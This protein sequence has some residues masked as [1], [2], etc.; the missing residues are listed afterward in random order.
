[1][2]FPRLLLLQPS[3][4]MEGTD[5][6]K[7]QFTNSIAAKVQQMESTAIEAA[8]GERYFRF[9]TIAKRAEI[10]LDNR[11]FYRQGRRRSWLTR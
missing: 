10:L 2:D 1:M 11:F 8:E 9:S 6:N 4:I 3:Y 7:M 5:F